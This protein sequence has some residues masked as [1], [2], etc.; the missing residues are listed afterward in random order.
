MDVAAIILVR[1]ATNL[2]YSPHASDQRRRRH[3]SPPHPCGGSPHRATASGDLAHHRT[4]WFRRRGVSRAPSIHGRAAQRHRSV[5]HAR[6]DGR[7]GVRT[8]RT[9]GNAVA[10]AP[11]LRDRDVH[12]RRHP[13][14]PRQQ[15]WRRPHQ[16]WR[17]AVDDRRRR[18]PAHRDS[19]GV[20]C[21]ERR[22]LPRIPAVGQPGRQGQDD[23]AA[24]PGDQGERDPGS[25]ASR[26]RPHQGDRG[27]ARWYRGT[28]QRHWRRADV[29]GRDGAQ[30]RDVRASAAC[31]A[32]GLPVPVRGQSRSGRGRRRAA[33]RQPAAR[34]R[35]NDCGMQ[36]KT[37]HPQHCVGL[38][39]C[40]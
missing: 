4:R 13:R 33:D 26:W 11:W 5:H 34:G 7:G 29:P 35:C 40:R 23:Q 37:A 22:P 20:P 16:R 17:H 18:H 27:F 1:T 15:R 2:V 14:S 25:V 6:P 21:G 12:A 31:R 30:G 32:E 39:H 10:S 3:A 19:P 28:D 8:G 36:R 9:E 38:Q 24:L